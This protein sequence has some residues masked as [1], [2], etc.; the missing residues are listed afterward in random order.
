MGSEKS[1]KKLNSLQLVSHQQAVA[2]KQ[3]GFDWNCDSVYWMDDLNEV[4]FND[5]LVLQNYNKISNWFS[6]PTVALALKWMLDVKGY[7]FDV[8]W[9]RFMDN[10]YYRYSIAGSNFDAD[11]DCFNIVAFGTSE[12]AESA[13]LDELIKLCE[14][15]GE[16]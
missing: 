12:Q 9:S 6:A 2:L 15:G 8:Y 7:T 16:K 11:D 5:Q 14:E 3:L 4:K 10:T 1:G 13:L